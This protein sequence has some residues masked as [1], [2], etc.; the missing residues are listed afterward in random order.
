MPPSSLRPKNSCLALGLASLA[1]LLP[2]CH[3]SAPQISDP[4]IRM[5]GNVESDLLDEISGIQASHRNPG[6]LWVHN[7]DGEPRIH[8]LGPEGQDLGSVVITDAVNADWEDITRIP[9][10]E[11]DLLVMADIG[12]N[13][14]RRSKVW[15]YIA[16]EPSPGPDG[17]FAGEIPIINWISLTYPEGPR[18]AEGVAW[19]PIKQRL[20]ILTKRDAVPRLYALDGVVALSESEAEL[21]FLTEVDSLRRPDPQDAQN[22]GK[23]APFGSQPTGF[24][25]S[26][27]GQYAAIITYRSLYLFAVPEDG[28]WETG[29]NTK[30]VE[31]V[32]PASPQEEAVSFDADGNGVWISTE[33]ER[34]PIYEFRFENDAAVSAE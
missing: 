25:L 4:R 13:S 8:A 21:L 14:A 33:G 6:V 17:R 11:R 24:D 9:G 12:D 32:G 2:A 22:L 19:D 7:D 5:A 23:R 26:A 27:D 30:P 29:L 15:L 16:E 28:D 10:K 3:E 31:I 20:L 34:S 1:L 18:D